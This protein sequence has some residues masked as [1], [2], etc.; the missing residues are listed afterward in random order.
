MGNTI[1]NCVAPRT[2]ILV[3]ERG[4]LYMTDIFRRTGNSCVVVMKERTSKRE[5]NNAEAHTKQ[6]VLTGNARQ[7]LKKYNYSLPT[8]FSEMKYKDVIFSKLHTGIKFDKSQLAEDEF[9]CGR[10]YKKKSG[11]TTCYMETMTVCPPWKIHPS[12][13]ETFLASN[14]NEY[15]ADFKRFLEQDERFKDVIFLDF[16]V[17]MNECYYPE[18]RELP[19]GTI[20][21]IPEAER[22]QYCYIKPHMDISYIPTVRDMD[23]KTGIEYLKLS[24]KDLWHSDNGFSKSYSEFLDRKMALDKEYE[25]ERGTVYQDMPEDEQPV[26]MTL[27]EWQKASDSKNAQQL[28]KQE[29]EIIVAE[30]QQIQEAK[31]KVQFEK[32]ELDEARERIES[33]M[34]DYIDELSK[35][36]WENNAF[37][38]VANKSKNDILTMALVAIE[39]IIKPLQKKFPEV[40][41]DIMAVIVGTR[42]KLKSIERYKNGFDDKTR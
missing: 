32:E 35:C 1:I 40:F 6:K 15:F 4:E 42:E 34:E 16:Q 24:R 31:E 39:R 23:K 36:G 30:T 19:D 3:Y 26:R 37:D 8:E 20:E 5:I 17:H 29:K 21:L 2:S 12:E 25:F 13:I 33:D 14:A 9:W 11:K 38:S 18:T 7:E 27:Q 41:T 22:E 28:I 10:T